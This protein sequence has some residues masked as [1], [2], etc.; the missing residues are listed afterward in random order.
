MNNRST[1]IKIIEFCS[2]LTFPQLLAFKEK[3]R[4]DKNK[5]YMIANE[6]IRIRLKNKHNT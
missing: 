3:Y 4:G 2:N 1:Y 5:E 6:V